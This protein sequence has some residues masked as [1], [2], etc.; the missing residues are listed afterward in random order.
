MD[1]LDIPPEATNAVTLS[2]DM[3]FDIPPELPEGL[4][5][6]HY[7]SDNSM[8]YNADSSSAASDSLN[9]GLDQVNNVSDSSDVDSLADF[10]IPD[11][12]NDENLPTLQFEPEPEPE[13][14]H[15]DDTI[16]D[17]PEPP[18]VEE[19]YTA[20]DFTVDFMMLFMCSSSVTKNA[21]RRI[22]SMVKQLVNQLA[23][24]LPPHLSGVLNFGSF[25]AECSSFK[26]G[27]PQIYTDY[28]LEDTEAEDPE[29]SLIHLNRLQGLQ[30]SKYPPHRF[31]KINER[32]YSDLQE[33]IAF[34]NKHHEDQRLTGRDIILSWDH[35]PESKS[36]SYSLSVIALTLS[37]CKR[38][39][40][41]LQTAKAYSGDHDSFEDLI[42]PILAQIE[43]GQHNLVRFISDKVVNYKYIINHLHMYYILFT[44][45][46]QGHCPEPPKPRSGLS[47]W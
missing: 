10:N 40:V 21:A 9:G 18:E 46:V 11:L 3:D 24:D 42:H 13:P 38:R 28:I 25:D 2:A 20:K 27:L 16:H 47:L 26:E 36:Q 14:V 39:P 43:E 15:N 6:P 41:A 22:W 7:D 30:T 31:K 35:V 4:Q 12:E 45:P 1:I 37:N 32:S 33:T 17:L 29:R 34:I 44:F 8:N 5:V 19:I 23:P